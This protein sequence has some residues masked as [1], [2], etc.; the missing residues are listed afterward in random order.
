MSRLS[1]IFQIKYF[2]LYNAGVWLIVGL[3]S[4]LWYYSLASDWNTAYNLR[5]SIR[6]PLATVLSFWILS[7]VVFDLFLATRHYPKRWF[8]VFHFGISLVF[9][10]THKALSYLSGL[11]LERLFLPQESKTWQELIALWE[12][13]WFDI[14]VG[15]TVY[16]IILLV[17]L[18]LENRHR[19]HSERLIS[20]ELQNQLSEGQLDQ[21]KLQMQPHFLFNALNT[22]AMMV[23]KNDQPAA[24]TMLSSLSEMLRNSLSQNRQAFVPLK[25]ELQ[26]ID[27]YL[28]IEKSRYQDRLT[29][30]QTIEDEAL[31]VKVPNLI[32]QPI[33]ENAFKHGI[34]QSLQA[35][36]LTISAQLE[37][38]QL[39]M[40]VFNTG[41]QLPDD[42]NFVSHQ[43]IGLG[44][45]VNRL[46]QLYQGNFK[47]QITERED[48]V[49]VRIVLPQTNKAQ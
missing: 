22:I 32:L 25:D 8:G 28:T 11:L 42:W 12:Q 47:F 19:Y 43:G 18:A 14:F 13:T 45:T 21:M 31:A 35:A 40:E 9:G 48:G 33:V 34:S 36:R 5:S 24:I 16:W 27:Q 44:N 41:N 29:V 26:L 17:L 20:R 39:V 38:D 6:H 3:I 37:P 2:L 7:F 49:L 15:V 46:M 23:R 30:E 4:L 1:R 10:A